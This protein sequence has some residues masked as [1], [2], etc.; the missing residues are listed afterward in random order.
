MGLCCWRR[1]FVGISGQCNPAAGCL[2]VHRACKAL[3]TVREALIKQGKGRANPMA[4]MS[5]FSGVVFCL[6]LGLG[7]EGEYFRSAPL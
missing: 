7:F 6:L 3:R 2:G 5:S 4:W 1:D